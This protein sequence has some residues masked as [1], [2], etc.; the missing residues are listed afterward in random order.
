MIKYEEWLKTVDE[1]QKQMED[2]FRLTKYLDMEQVQIPDLVPSSETLYVREQL[3]HFCHELEEAYYQAKR[4]NAQVIVYGK[5]RKGENGRF[6]LDNEELA[7]G[8][9]IE[10]LYK[11]ENSVEKIEFWHAGHIAHNGYRYYFTGNRNIELEG[12]TARIKQHL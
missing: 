11:E 9:S 5:L 10:I 3:E 2:F 12:A 1:L 6:W 4:L 8:R 7:C